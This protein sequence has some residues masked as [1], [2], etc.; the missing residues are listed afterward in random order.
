MDENTPIVP[1]DSELISRA[2]S[3]EV[4]AFGELYKRYLDTIYR[5]IRVRVS[6]DLIAEDLTEIVFLR[7]YERLE[8]YKERGLPFSAF[9]YRVARNLLVDHYRQQ[10]GDALLEDVDRIGISEPAP[11]DRVITSESIQEVQEALTSLPADYQEIIRLRVVLDL[12]TATAAAWIGRSE[13]AV[14]VLLHRA[15]KALRVR[16]SESEE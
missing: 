1:E 16:M 15:L 11:E 8:G 3:G 14:R 13:G 2:Q 10:Q 6:E 7:S 5:Y 4:E 9:L 12:P